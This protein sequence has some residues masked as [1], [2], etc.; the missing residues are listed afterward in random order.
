MEEI[1]NSVDWHNDKRTD[2]NKMMLNCNEN[3]DEK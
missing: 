1:I 2:D 3:F